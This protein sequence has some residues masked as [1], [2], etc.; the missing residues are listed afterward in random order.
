MSLTVARA[1]V[2][3]RRKPLRFGFLLPVLTLVLADCAR[4]PTRPVQRPGSFVGADVDPVW[5]NDGHTIAFRRRGFSS[6]GPPGIY[7]MSSTGGPMRFITPADFF[8][9]TDLRFSP[10]N[11]QLLCVVGLNLVVINLADL[12]SSTLP[13]Y[14]DP[15]DGQRYA[16]DPDWSPD[17]RSIVYSFNGRIRMFD[18][19]SQQ[20]SLLHP[21]PTVTTDT[22]YAG[23]MPCWS[24]DGRQIAFRQNLFTYYVIATVNPDGR[25]LKV[26]HAP[27]L[28]R[29]EI[30]HYLA[31]YVDAARGMDG[32]ICDQDQ[33]PGYSLYVDRN[34]TTTVQLPYRLRAHQAFS[35][36]GEWLV[37]AAPDLREP[38]AALFIQRVGDPSGASRRQV[39]YWDEPASTSVFH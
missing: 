1:E 4:E 13:T 14:V 15:D 19:T 39:T 2:S 22:A 37:E 9:P 12:S 29:T 16:T 11:S 26:L 7:T 10:D 33:R 5:S 21:D 28:G 30:Y 32:V 18:L 34:G 20:D 3:R 23:T 35:P 24:R 27:S 38:Y 25:N 8:W 31:W 6:A 17:G 36:D